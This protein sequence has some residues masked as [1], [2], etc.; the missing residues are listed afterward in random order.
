MNFLIRW[1]LSLVTSLVIVFCTVTFVV[2][3]SQ[4][5]RGIVAFLYGILIAE[6]ASRIFKV[7]KAPKDSKFRFKEGHKVLVDDKG[8]YVITGVYTKYDCRGNFQA[9]YMVRIDD[10]EVPVTLDRITDSPK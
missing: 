4:V 1:I 3:S 9:G 2:S 7:D 8:P 6:I 10:H 5:N